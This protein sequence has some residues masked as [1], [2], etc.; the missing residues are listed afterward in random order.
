MARAGR[1]SGEYQASRLFKTDTL[2]RDHAGSFQ[3]A[4]AAAHQKYQNLFD[5]LDTIYRI[6]KQIISLFLFSLFH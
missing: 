1:L 2:V 5:A 6:T 4:G 3:P